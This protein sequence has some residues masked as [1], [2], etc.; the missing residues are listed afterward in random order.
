MN[1]QCGRPTG[2]LLIDSSGDD[3]QVCPHF[4]ERNARLQPSEQRQPTGVVL[5]K[6]IS[7]GFQ[8]LLHRHRRPKLA[9]PGVDPT[10]SRRGHANHREFGAV[11]GNVLAHNLRI[12]AELAPPQGV[13]QHHH[14]PRSSRAAILLHKRPT[15]RRPL[16]QNME[17]V[18]GRLRSRQLFRV[19]SS[20]RRFQKGSICQQS[21]ENVIVRSV[22]LVFGVRKQTR[23]AVNVAPNFSMNDLVDAHD[24]FRT[25]NRQKFQ[26]DPVQNG[27]NPR[28]HSDSERRCQ[29]HHRRESRILRQRPSPVSKIAPGGFQRRE[30]P[31]LAA[32][33]LDARDVSELAP[34]RI[35]RLFRRYP[36]SALLFLA[37]RQVKRQLFIQVLFQLPPPEERPHPRPNSHNYS[38]KHTEIRLF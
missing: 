7:V 3:C 20:Q 19:F 13:A 22:V 15:Q 33:F 27:K 6:Q 24:L 35:L 8:C 11:Q 9:G 10:K 23:L 18:A 32:G 28:I 1:R 34:R 37:H 31:R 5:E 14:R 29:H 17:E 36:C 25:G 4:F 30:A 26:S 16:P 21:G 12:R 38:S 2:I